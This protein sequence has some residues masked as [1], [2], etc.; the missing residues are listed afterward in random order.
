MRKSILLFIAVAAVVAF[1]IPGAFAT[2]TSP[3]QENIDAI[4]VEMFEL[5]KKL[6]ASY[7][8]SGQISEEQATAML[9]RMEYATE[10]RGQSQKRGFIK[11]FG[12][13]CGFEGRSGAAGVSCGGPDGCNLGSDFETPTNQVPG[14]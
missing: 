13:G 14:L 11:G 5:R 9:E 6:L 3:Q 4:Y 7:V 2:T 8:A 12:G 10:K 1:T